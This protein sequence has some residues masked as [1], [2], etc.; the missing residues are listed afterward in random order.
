MSEFKARWDG[1]DAEQSL[2]DY[3][4]LS[5]T[6]ILALITGGLSLTAIWIPAMSLFGFIAIVF[7][8][9]AAFSQRNQP[10][11]LVW[12][13]YLGVFIAM[14]GIVWSLTGRSFY[15]NHM[16]SLGE[17]KA[18]EWLK[19]LI[20]GK[21]N[22]AVCLRM[23]YWERPLEGVDLDEY[24][25]RTERAPTSSEMTPPPAQLKEMFLESQTIRH[26]ISS[27]SKTKYTPLPE[28]TVYDGSQLGKVN[29]EAYFDVQFY[30]TDSLGQL[31]E[32]SAEIAVQVIRTKYPTGIHWQVKRL[33]NVTA[34]DPLTPKM[35]QPAG[36]VTF[37]EPDPT[38]GPEDSP[39]GN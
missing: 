7:A 11:S 16:V 2:D 32:T 10:Q 1:S 27:G 3:R 22:Q 36:S 21:V 20:D 33:T 38:P 31:R 34:P 23:D 30:L 19:L 39:P 18:E 24:F 28:K 26:L 35:L 37:E 29:I 6:S 25:L 17:Q 4:P 8:V 9:I 12:A 15:Q 13:G 14:I 5:V